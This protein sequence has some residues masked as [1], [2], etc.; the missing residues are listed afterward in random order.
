MIPIPL[1]GKRRA[2]LKYP[3][4]DLSRK[5]IRVIKKALEFIES[6]LLDEEDDLL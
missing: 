4:E 3:L 6:S 2:Y 5:D 1:G